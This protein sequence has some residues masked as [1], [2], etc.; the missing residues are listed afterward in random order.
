MTK[1]LRIAPAAALLAALL[2]SACRADDRDLKLVGTVE[3]TLIELVAPASEVIVEIRAERGRHV[4]PGELL[5]RFDGTLADAE[6][7]RSEAML[8][9]ARASVTLAES[10]LRRIRKLYGQRVSSEQELERAQLGRAEAQA[11]QREAEALLTAAVKH[12]QDLEL[13]APSAG[14]VDQI[15]FDPGERVPAGAVVLVL[16]EDAPPWVR[17]WVPEARF[18][19]VGPGTP[20]EIRI[21]G[22]ASPL[23]GRVL[24]VAREPEFTPHFALTERDRVYLV[25]ETRVLIEDAPPG[26]RPGLPAEV[27]LD[28][29]PSGSGP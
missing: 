28:A 23:H 16:M 27:A 1:H 9:S 14:V 7:A 12:R 20:A 22:I 19:R 4:E 13:R 15:P 6:I 29:G 17:V 24:D 3:R 26:L 5:V 2:L 11:R 18:A 10:E 8:A 25:Y 21:D